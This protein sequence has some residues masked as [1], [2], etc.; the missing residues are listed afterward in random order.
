MYISRLNIL[1]A[2]GVW[3]VTI[4]MAVSIYLPSQPDDVPW[5]ETRAVPTYDRFVILGTYMS[6]AAQR[7]LRRQCANIRT[8]HTTRFLWRVIERARGR[9]GWGKEEATGSLVWFFIYLFFLFYF[10]IF[11][12]TPTTTIID[13]CALARACVRVHDLSCSR[14]HAHARVFMYAAQPNCTAVTAPTPSNMAGESS[15]GRDLRVVCLRTATSDACK[16]FKHAHLITTQ[17][18]SFLYKKPFYR[19]ILIRVS[20]YTIL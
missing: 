14:S 15:R 6:L 9:A 16:K 13:P 7:R 10:F 2:R 17:S 3:L 19:Y 8:A 4:K 20:P 18:V 5:G 12:T 1:T 11:T